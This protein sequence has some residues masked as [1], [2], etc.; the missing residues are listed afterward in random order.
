MI[1][2]IWLSLAAAFF[3]LLLFPL[4]F[5]ELMVSGLAKLHLAPGAAGLAVL[6]VLLGGFVNIPVLRVPHEEEVTVDPFA[7]FGLTGFWPQIQR[8]QRETIIA[9]NV[10]GCLVPTGLAIY[11]SVYLA[12]T[13]PF[14]L[15]AA[16]IASAITI[17][18]CYLLARPVPGLGIAVPGLVPP[19]I[20]TLAAMLLAPDQAPPVAFIAGVAGPLVGADLMNLRNLSRLGAGVMS[21]GGAGTFDGI[22]LSGVIAAYLA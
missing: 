5:S 22:V 1:L 8:V 3:L 2:L 13:D 20:A 11:E 14:A 18:A 21:I 7:A 9:V 10:G 15:L 19:L 12:L 6:L 16:L 4:L 17:T